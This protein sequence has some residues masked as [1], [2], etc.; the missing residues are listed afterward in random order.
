MVSELDHYRQLSTV[1]EDTLITMPHGIETLVEVVIEQSPLI[2]SGGAIFR[3]IYGGIS[4]IADL[5]FV[6]GHDTRDLYTMT[7][8]THGGVRLWAETYDADEF[9]DSAAYL[10]F[11]VN[12]DPILIG[13]RLNQDGVTEFKMEY[14]MITGPNHKTEERVLIAAKR[15]PA[16][17]G[18]LKRIKGMLRFKG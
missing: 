2:D 16:V 9:M 1:T 6:T 14:L 5:G 15:A 13:G 11:M 7:L 12:R 10:Q 18:L 17:S 8:Y 4:V 3:G